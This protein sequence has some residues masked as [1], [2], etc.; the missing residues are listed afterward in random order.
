MPCNE[1][2]RG[3]PS[4]TLIYKHTLSTIWRKVSLRSN[5]IY[6]YIYIYCGGGLCLLRVRFGHCY[7]AIACNTEAVSS[8]C[9]VSYFMWVCSSTLHEALYIYIYIYVIVDDKECILYLCD[10]VWIYNHLRGEGVKWWNT[11]HPIC[12][13]LIGDLHL[14]RLNQFCCFYK[15][16]NEAIENV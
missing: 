5:S 16:W 1:K 4:H 6:I 14:R 11:L 2:E 10:C 13:S 15:I 8:G 9:K 12:M 7:F 3:I